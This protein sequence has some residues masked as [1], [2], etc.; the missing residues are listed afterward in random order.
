MP[1]SSDPKPQQ[2]TGLSIAAI[3]ILSTAFLAVLALHLVQTDLDPVRDVM[4]GYANGPFGNLMT[5]SF[6]AL[7]IGTIV[8]AVRLRRS[9]DRSWAPITIS[10]ALGLGGL[11][12]I[13]AGVFEVERPGVPD[14]LNEIVHSNGAIA[15]FVLIVIAMVL[16]PYVCYRDERWESFLV[17]SL[18]LA[19][20]AVA[21]AAFSPVAPSTTIAGLA[22]RVLAVV[23][24]GWVLLV[25][26]WMRFRILPSG[27]GGD[28]PG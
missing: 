24:F 4:S 6:Y 16:F 11:A 28:H 26:I 14:T 7:G 9:T 10:M 22:Q 19:I 23:V 27:G 21:A 3:I 1:E 2:A 15:G 5:F 8:L 13:L 12:L 18:S 17:P 20:I 25:A